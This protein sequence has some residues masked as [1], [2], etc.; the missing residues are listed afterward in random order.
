MSGRTHLD[1][2]PS[3]IVLDANDNAILID[4]GGTDGFMWEWLSLEMRILIRQSCPVN[5]PLDA[6]IVGL[7]GDRSQLSLKRPRSGTLEISIRLQV[8]AD[9]LTKATPESRISLC[10]ALAQLDEK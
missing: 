3:N 10:D 2:K 9:R 7:M 4:V 1:I 5:K 6:R 8:I